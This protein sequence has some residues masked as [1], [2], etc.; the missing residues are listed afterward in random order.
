[1][2]EDTLTV[3][4]DLTNEVKKI[5]QFLNITPHQFLLKVIKEKLSFFQSVE[6]YTDEDIAQWTQAD[7][8]SAEKRQ[9]ILQKVG[10]S[11]D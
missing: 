11:L 4:A 7:Q 6:M 8:L 1:M 2:T 5:A 9:R 10:I 3:P